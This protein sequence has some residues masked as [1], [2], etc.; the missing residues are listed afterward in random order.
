MGTR[1]DFNSVSR[2]ESA[3]R[4]YQHNSDRLGGC[5]AMDFAILPPEV[6]SG[7]MYDGPG[8]GPM[9]AAAAAGDGLA[10]DLHTAAASYGSVIAELSAGP[11]LGA[12]SSAMTTAVEPY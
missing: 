6:N 1:G 10:T 11:W 12:A 3:H 9:L 5:A 2:I 7:R 4:R 8:S